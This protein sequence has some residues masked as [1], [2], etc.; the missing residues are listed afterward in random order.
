MLEW[1]AIAYSSGFSDK[2]F[3]KIAIPYN[4]YEPKLYNRWTMKGMFDLK[5][6]ILV[7]KEFWDF[8]G[9][10]G[11]YETLLQIFEDVGI[12]LKSEI[13]ARFAKFR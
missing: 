11:T 9:G 5:N 8:L 10:E 7:G 13:D 2:V 6:Q 3:A 12:E 1:T 4:P